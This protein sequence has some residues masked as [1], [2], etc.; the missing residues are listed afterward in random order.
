MVRLLKLAG[1]VHKAFVRLTMAYGQDV[2]QLV[3]GGLHSTILYLPSDLRGKLAHSRLPE[4]WMMPRVALDADSPALLGHSKNE[5]P[6][7]LWVQIGI[8]QYQQALILLQPY[9]LLQIIEK[10]PSMKLPHPRIRANSGLYYLLLIQL[11]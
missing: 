7:L 11:P 1:A 2:R 6:A 4:V 5:S 10:L 8:G 9:I 3:A